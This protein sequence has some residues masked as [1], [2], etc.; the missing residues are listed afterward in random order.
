MCLFFPAA[1]RPPLSSARIL[2]FLLLCSALLCVGSAPLRSFYSA[3]LGPL[4]LLGFVPFFC[5]ALLFLRLSLSSALLC[6]ALFLSSA[7]PCFRPSASPFL[8]FCS[9]PGPPLSASASLL[10]VLWFFVP[11]CSRLASLLSWPAFFLYTLPSINKL[12]PYR[13]RIP[14]KKTKETHAS[15][16]LHHTE[17]FHRTQRDH[18]CNEVAPARMSWAPAEVSHQDFRN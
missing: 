11:P 6:S 9:G 13:R 4:P 5:S 3:L 12:F 16:R 17:A 8:S 14:W 15:G 18:R 2:S 10:A 1:S 7:L